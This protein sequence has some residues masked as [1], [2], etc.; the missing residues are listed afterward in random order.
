MAR[1]R[2]EQANTH[3]A[4]CLVGGRERRKNDRARSFPSPALQ[5]AWQ[6]LQWEAH[7][8]NNIRTQLLPPQLALRGRAARCSRLPAALLA[9]LVCAVIVS[10][11]SPPISH[12]LTCSLSRRIPSTFRSGPFFARER[13]KER[14]ERKKRKKRRNERKERKEKKEKKETNK[15]SLQ[16]GSLAASPLLTD[17]S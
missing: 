16:P 14:K 9:S 2:G 11:A 4:A 1:A 12:A 7:Q 13:R 15:R 8:E 17:Q 10:P 5:V 3:S 6:P